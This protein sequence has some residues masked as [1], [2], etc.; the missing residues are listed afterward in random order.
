MNKTYYELELIA[1]DENQVPTTRAFEKYLDPDIALEQYSNYGI[2]NCMAKLFLVEEEN[3]AK[4]RYIIKCKVNPKKIKMPCKLLDAL[5]N[6]TALTISQQKAYNLM[7]ASIN[8][9]VDAK[10]A[11]LLIERLDDLM[12]KMKY[13][14]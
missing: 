11:N 8:Y 10:Y 4:H 1:L 3:N 6:D 13:G 9:Y 14:Q 12:E 2:P 5:K 7:I